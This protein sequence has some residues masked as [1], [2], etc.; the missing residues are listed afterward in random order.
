MCMFV[1]VTAAAA[2]IVQY[3]HLLVCRCRRRR[4]LVLTAFPLESQHIMSSLLIAFY[5][6][7]K[8]NILS[9]QSFMVWS[10]SRILLR[11]QLILL[12][13]SR[14]VVHTHTNVVDF[15]FWF[16]FR[17]YYCFIYRW[18]IKKKKKKYTL[19]YSDKHTQ[20]KQTSERTNE[21]T[22]ERE[23]AN[24]TFSWRVNS[25]NGNRVLW[26]HLLWKISVCLIYYIVYS[27][28]LVL[29]Y[30]CVFVSGV[31][32][33]FCPTFSFSLSLSLSLWLRFLFCE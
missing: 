2:A 32:C 5:F 4:L 16:W 10:S 28:L 14:V 12:F 25:S 24:A 27:V 33:I 19:S 26:M 1:G 17:F 31:S 6:R 23:N 20:S 9:I 21:R 3:V 15:R 7:T 18:T 29:I 22:S 30:L 8:V 13:S 11:C